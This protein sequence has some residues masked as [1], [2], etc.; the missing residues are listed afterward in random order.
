MIGSGGSIN[1]SRRWLVAGLLAGAIVRVIALPLP[2]TVDTFVWKIWSYSAAHDVTRVYGVGGVPPIRR[3]LWWQGNSTTVNYPPVAM[4]ELALAGRLYRH[5]RPAF[6]DSPWLNV[7]VKLPGQIAEAVFVA[8][9]LTRGSRWLG[10]RAPWAALAFW[11]NPLVVLNGAVLGYL[12]AQMAVPL[13]LAMIAAWT[14]GAFAAGILVAIAVATKPQAIFVIPAILVTLLAR[15]KH[16]R[17]LG[18]AVAGGAMTVAFVVLPFIWRGAG[19]NLAQ[20]VGRVATHDMLSGEAANVWWIFTWFLRVVDARDDWGWSRAL[21]QEVRILGITNAEAL[22][23]P[24]ARAVGIV[25]TAVA[26]GWACWRMRRLTRFSQAA[27][28]S[29]WCGYAYAML[30]AQVHENHWYAVVPFLGLAAAADRRYRAAFVGITAVAALNLYLFYGFGTGWPPIIHRS[31]TAIDM[32]VL[33]SV[34]NV[35]VFVWFGRQLA[36]DGADLRGGSAES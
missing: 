29:A 1:K 21:T 27:A 13:V 19:R 25:L 3:V 32:T 31:W 24:N 10:D 6:D 18:L 9:L 8:L 17:A 33:L 11:L 34:L 4:G 20:A 7:C 14:G 26:I 30:F 2:G 35:G 23:Y 22:G 5:F 36:T 16:L 12:D 15:A 28:L